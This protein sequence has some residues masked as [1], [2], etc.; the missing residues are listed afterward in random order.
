MT[1]C[2]KNLK[3][4]IDFSSTKSI[5]CNF[6]IFIFPNF[7]L[8]ILDF[9]DFYFCNFD[10]LQGFSF[11]TFLCFIDYL[12]LLFFKFSFFTSNFLKKISKLDICR[13]NRLS[14]IRNGKNRFHPCNKKSEIGDLLKEKIEILSQLWIPRQYDE[15]R[16]SI[17]SKPRFFRLFD[18]FSTFG[19]LRVNSKKSRNQEA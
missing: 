15:K 8:L 2:T 11:S 9:F 14:K 4:G 18:F 1:F 7:P 13:K 12:I 19:F 16:F 10:D 5:F 3:V 17:L 6:N